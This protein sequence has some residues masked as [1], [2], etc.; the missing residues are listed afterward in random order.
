MKKYL[1]IYNKNGMHHSN[2][3]GDDEVINWYLN[4]G[5]RV[6]VFD[7]VKHAIVWSSCWA[8]KEGI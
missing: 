2:V 8:I 7:E 6:D 3:Y 4:K 5:M 1:I